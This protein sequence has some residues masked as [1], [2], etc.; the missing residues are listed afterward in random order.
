MK[1]DTKM[2]Q[3]VTQQMSVFK[4]INEEF[5]E[6]LAMDD[7]CAV[8]EK[9]KKLQKLADRHFQTI[10]PTYPFKRITIQ[11]ENGVIGFQHSENFVKCFS[12]Y[13]QDVV[14]IGMSR[15]KNEKFGQFIQTSCGTN[16]RSIVFQDCYLSNLFLEGIANHLRNIESM[17]LL[18]QCYDDK[19]KFSADDILKYCPRIRFL[20]IC[21]P[22]EEIVRLP[23]EEYETLEELAF[24][25]IDSDQKTD[26]TNCL[27]QNPN[28]KKFI[29]SMQYEQTDLVKFV[30]YAIIGTLN[31]EELFLEFNGDH[32]DFALIREELKMLDDRE[33]F[34]R[35]EIKVTNFNKSV[36]ALKHKLDLPVMKRFS[37]FHLKYWDE[38]VLNDLGQRLSTF[39]AFVNVKILQIDSLAISHKLATNLASNLPNLE[40]AYFTRGS[41]AAGALNLHIF[42]PFVRHAPKLSKLFFLNVTGFDEDDYKIGWLNEE[43]KKLENEKKSEKLTIYMNRDFMKIFRI[44]NRS[45][46]TYL[47]N[48]KIILM[49]NNHTWNHENPFLGFNHQ[50]VSN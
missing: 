37:G 3:T 32:I 15:E 34:K 38:R 11:E 48:I 29:C 41:I 13:F 1:G 17:Q 22:S 16:L 20:R 39:D 43:R 47:V 12:R 40:E 5:V 25:R 9:C 4:S 2:D 7:L 26:L 10:Y 18:Y 31:I 19:D 35:L 8:S 33:N 44:S 24:H 36:P 14:V 6:Q 30:L 42:R 50:E 21:N 45:M 49:D 46:E 27:K 28:I 23:Q